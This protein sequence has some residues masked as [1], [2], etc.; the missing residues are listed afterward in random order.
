MHGSG[1]EG[2]RIAPALVV[3]LGGLAVLGVLLWVLGPSDDAPEAADP[4]DGGVR[5]TVLG[6]CDAL[7]AASGGS[8]GDADAVFYDRSHEGLHDL[9]R[10]A[11]GEDRAAV[12]RLLETKQRVEALLREDARGGELAEELDRL[13]E[14]AREAARAV[15]VPPP[16][17]PEGD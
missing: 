5:E 12:T 7:G 3:L 17:C 10:R 8:V 4:E 1:S 13:L 9:A 16:P 2:G 14:A 11:S 15:D 6:L